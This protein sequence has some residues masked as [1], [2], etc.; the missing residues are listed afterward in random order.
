MLE[1]FLE[2]GEETLTAL[3]EAYDNES[4][5]QVRA[6]AHKLKS[7]ARTVGAHI[8]ADLC[9]GLEAAGRENDWAKINDLVPDAIT[10]LSQVKNRI[11]A[12]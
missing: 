7:A 6:C 2:S 10:A 1:E 5:D 9:E 11:S 3:S 12:G 8:L 4:A